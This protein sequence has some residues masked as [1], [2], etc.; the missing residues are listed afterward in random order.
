MHAIGR[1]GAR[2]TLRSR[3]QQQQAAP[4]GNRPHPLE[5]CATLDGGKAIVTEHHAR[6]ARQ[7]LERTP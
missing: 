7:P 4:P 6:P 5:Q 1:P 3:Q 2:Q